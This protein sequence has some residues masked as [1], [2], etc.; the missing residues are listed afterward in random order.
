MNVGVALRNPLPPE[1]PTFAEFVYA[2]RQRTPFPWQIR[3][4][5]ALVNGEDLDWLVVPTGLGKTSIIDAWC[6]A[7]AI[8]IARNGF[9]RTIAT[10]L[11]FVV[12]RR[13]IVDDSAVFAMQLSQKLGE[14]LEDATQSSSSEGA[15]LRWV[16]RQLM[17]SG[18]LLVSPL[19]VVKMRGGVSWDWRWLRQPDQPAVVSSTVDQF[20]SRLLF[21]GY[22]VGD[23]ISPID[24]A[25]VSQ[26]S[27]VVLDEAHLSEPLAETI[28]SV[29]SVQAKA[30]RFPLPARPLK[31]LRMTA[32]PPAKLDARESV[33]EATL[34]VGNDDLDDLTAGK[35]F[36]ASKQLHFVEVVS[37]KK[38]SKEAFVQGIALSVQHQ[39]MALVGQV[40]DP[41][42]VV[43]VNTVATARAARAAISKM[44]QGA[45]VSLVIGQSRS[46]ERSMNDRTWRARIQAGRI[47]GE[48]RPFV[49][50]ATQT[51]EVGADIDADALITEACAFDS[52]VQRLGRLDRF[53]E[54]SAR[55]GAAQAVLLWNEHRHGTELEPACRVYGHAATG[56][57]NM[58]RAKASP[59]PDDCI[60][61]F[62]PLSKK[63]T[64]SFEAFPALG[65]GPSDLANLIGPSLDWSKLRLP[66]AHAPVLLPGALSGWSRTSPRPVPDRSIVPYLH[67][68]RSAEQEIL[69]CWRDLT[70]DGWS[71]EL[72]R[73]PPVASEC[74]SLRVSL[75]RDFLFPVGEPSEV[76]TEDSDVLEL[77]AE[78]QAPS[79]LPKKMRAR[80]LE[81]RFAL[82]NGDWERYEPSDKERLFPDLT[83]Q[84]MLVLDCPS[85]GHDAY[86]FNP[87]FEGRVEDVADLVERRTQILR[88]S[89]DRILGVP[90]DASTSETVSNLWGEIIKAVNENERGAVLRVLDEIANVLGVGLTQ[91]LSS[92]GMEPTG[93]WYSATFLECWREFV[94]Q[95]NVTFWILDRSVQNNGQ[96]VI[97]GDEEVVRMRANDVIVLR[98]EVDY[99]SASKSSVDVV[100][101]SDID[102]SRTSAVP[103]SLR[104]HLL[105]VAQRARIMA[106]HLG[107][108]PDLVNAV[109]ISADLHDL[110][111]ADRRF[112][113]ILLNGDWIKAELEDGNSETTLAKSAPV[114]AKTRS[115]VP[116]E[117]RWPKGKRHEAVSVE[118]LCSSKEWREEVLARD[119]DLVLHLVGSHHGHA[120]PLFPPVVD[121]R[122]VP[123][124]FEHSSFSFAS[125]GTVSS[126]DWN[127]PRRFQSLCDEFSP[128]G[129]AL[130]E[131][132]VRL[133]DIWVSEEGR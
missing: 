64:L 75:L 62:E 115:E 74:V 56:T 28:V 72:E 43:I 81:K 83:R 116:S 129:L 33:E 92:V 27:L 36:G 105:A 15:A 20:G 126:I 79:K 8:D 2:A 42:V 109:A 104:S 77:P 73:I 127:A 103:V 1:A 58:L 12:N 70:S 123:V 21:R 76:G 107:L 124:S 68:P 65:V 119:Q 47:R 132:I 98:R 86:G 22:G 19:E 71:E 54:F 111:K 60:V 29:Q 112:Q 38:D 57:W 94:S 11:I 91:P 55:F 39:L 17:A 69:V 120:R 133:A 130:L 41:T 52:L 53:G 44:I 88:I 4:A 97:E 100:E 106:E 85:G 101:D 118:L 32:T 99:G 114:E 87:L 24:T 59:Q 35:R 102:S 13:G 122:P 117:I 61:K 125:E 9:S 37:P 93:S 34:S 66:P 23:R 48:R 49:L 18:T 10:R 96:P 110:G 26:D 128:W 80:R 90:N 45:D 113:S 78:E 108:S 121:V 3:L 5:T 95:P 50:V 84:A 89:R 131:A 16:A 40:D 51:V 30:A 67:G 46:F 6:W 25:L 31:F 82:L 7:L 14:S 63:P